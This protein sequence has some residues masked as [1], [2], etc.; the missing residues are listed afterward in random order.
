MCAF[1]ALLI[2]MV[3]SEIGKRYPS[4]R[5]LGI[6]FLRKIFFSKYAGNVIVHR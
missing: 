2:D 3:R 6:L 4:R 1:S 5:I